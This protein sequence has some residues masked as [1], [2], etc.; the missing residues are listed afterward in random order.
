MEDL[1]AF[2]DERLARTLVQSPVP[3]V[4][5]VGHETDFTI[6]DFV[7]DLRAPT[8]TAAAE[9]V[10]QPRAVWLGALDLLQEQLA[11]MPLARHLDRQSQRLDLAAS[12][13]GRPSALAAR[14]R[15]TLSA[16][17]QRLRY[18]ATHAL[19][20]R[21]SDRQASWAA[22]AA[23]PCSAACRRS[24]SAWSAQACAWNCSIRRWCCERGYAWLSDEH[25]HTV[26]H[27]AP[28]PC[29]AGPAGHPCRWQG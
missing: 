23:G 7:A 22:S 20:R 9:L 19:T 2:N 8:P 14:Q 16:Q 26:H 1:W 29:R 4:C 25:G 6:A 15:L 12:R 10:A 24:N 27:V 3:V 28:D 18:A 13:L 5:G 21:Q 11:L 17:A